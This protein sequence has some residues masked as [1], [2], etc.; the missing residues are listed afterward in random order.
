MQQD[1]VQFSH[2]ST[3]ITYRYPNYVLFLMLVGTMVLGN[4]IGSLLI[5]LMDNFTGYSSMILLGNGSIETLGERNYVRWISGLGHLFTF[6]IPATITVAFFYKNQWIEKMHLAIAPK[7]QNIIL[8]SLFVLLSFPLV[9]LSY[10]ANQ[11]VPIPEWAVKMEAA[12]EQLIESLTVMNSFPELLLN[13]LVIAIIPAI[14]EEIVFRGIIQ[15][16][17]QQ[18]FSKKKREGDIAERGEESLGYTEVDLN[19]NRTAAWLAI[20]IAAFI[21]SAFHFQFAGFLPRL[22]LG[23][24]LG[25]LFYWTRNL[26]VPIIAHA[27]VNGSQVF[28]KFYLNQELEDVT[29]ENNLQSFGPVFV[30]AT[31]AMIGLGYLLL[32][33][34]ARTENHTKSTESV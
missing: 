3:S 31:I 28:G 29:I 25:Y 5:L 30:V 22:I 1:K 34:N 16:K 9:Q 8:G 33:S 21:F 12:A 2:N 4:M 27:V 14:G 20:W 24:G 10:Y 15:Q 7:F 26:W 32:K 19:E 18:I 23:A 6:L 11:Q 13:L 17:L